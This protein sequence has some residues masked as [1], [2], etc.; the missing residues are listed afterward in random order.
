MSLSRSFIL[1]T[2]ALA[3]AA[4]SGNPSPATDGTDLQRQGRRP[5]IGNDSAR[6][7]RVIENARPDAPARAGLVVVANQEAGSAT[8]VD[9]A[10]M[11]TIA[12]LPVGTGPHE[13]A[14]SPDG[15]W[16]VVT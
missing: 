8:V 10:T 11:K 4:C 7:N 12:T 15:R 14:T 5:L 16:A 13:V 6:N 9:A 3:A 2:L 1:V